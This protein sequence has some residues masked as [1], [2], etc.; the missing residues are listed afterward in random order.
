MTTTMKPG[1]FSGAQRDPMTAA[2]LSLIPGLG[3]LYNGE[4]RKGFLFLGVAA[5]NFI[6]FL[7]M[8]FTQQILDALWNFGLSFH[9]KPNRILVTTLMEGRLGSAVS[10]ILLGFFLSFVAYAARDAYD[11]AALKRRKLYPDFVIQLPEATSGSYIVH[12][13]IMVALGFL[14]FFF[15]LPP[16]PKSHITDIEFIVNQPPTQKR[17][18]AR[19]RAEKAS[20]SHGKR[21][22]KKPVVAPN[23]APK[24]PSHNTAPSKPTPQKSE[25]KPSE[26]PTPQPKPAPIPMP[27]LPN[28]FAA[29]QPKVSPAPTPQPTAMPRVTPSPM[30]TPS[31][32]PMPHASAPKAP[33]M[34]SLAPSAMPRAGVGGPA[35]TPVARPSGGAQ[36][37][38]S[39]A[40]SAVPFAGSGG[41]APGFAPAPRIASAPGGGLFS[42]P[43]PIASPGGGGGGGAAGAPSPVPVPS[44]GG[45]GGKGGAGNP[46]G[47]GAP[48]PTRAGRSGGGGGGGAPG[49]AVAPSVPR[50]GGGGGS[51]EKGNPDGNDNGRPSVAAQAD[52]DFGPYMADLQRRIKR[53]WFPPKG[54][55]SKRVVVVFKIH[56]MGELSH[57]RIDHSSGVA[58]ADQ[59]A[60]KAVENAAPFRPL[61]NGAPDDVD[62]QFTF[63]YNV[64]GGGG[65]GVFRQF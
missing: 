1:G 26:Q 53:A 6:A 11:H 4:T 30:A 62:I 32:V 24:A 33:A 15:I 60:L 42:P 51:G 3:Q 54:N 47:G 2:M 56:K 27:S 50:A 40:P 10:F 20:E 39:I 31:P 29:P 48:A 37:L 34:P 46:A 63:D 57:L 21:D 9:M 38:P 55:E 8:L 25:S 65:R 13:S 45:G 41:G 58:V 12:F 36:G 5:L 14:C 7:G 18:T 23:P 59:A 19:K 44:S 49:I 28:F 17:V 61:P 16:P 43:A 64:F 35:P 22:P 52:V